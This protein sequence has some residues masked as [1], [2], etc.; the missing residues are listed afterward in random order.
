MPLNYVICP[1]D[2]DPADPNKYTRAL[3]A[4]SFETQDFRE[5]NREVYHLVNDLP[6]ETD[7]MTW[8]EKLHN[9]H[10]RTAHLLFCKPYVG[11][12]HDI[13]PCRDGGRK[14]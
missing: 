14:T 7:G 3:W 8:F 2:V 9:G 10:G 1:A 6:S 12:A 13:A 11:E 4:T 5:D